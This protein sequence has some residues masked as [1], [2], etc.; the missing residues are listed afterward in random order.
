LG[1]WGEVLLF[2]C[3]MLH[4]LFPLLFFI[5]FSFLLSLIFFLFLLTDLFIHSFFA[6]SFQPL[7]SLFSLSLS[8]AFP[9]HMVT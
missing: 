7:Y 2:G 8:L 9:S 1:G 3:I 4:A 5:S 6:Y